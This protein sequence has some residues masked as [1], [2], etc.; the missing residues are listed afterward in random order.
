MY[1]GDYE[2]NY[3]FRKLKADEI[4]CRIG[5]VKEDGVSLLLYKD[6]RVDM[7]ILDETFGCL[8]W[9]REHK[10]VKGVN[11]CGVS[12]YN[13]K[14]GQWITK[15]DAGKESN[16]EAEKGEA[17]DSFKRACVNFGIG[18][19]LYTSPKI[20]IKGGTRNDYYSVRSI[21]IS[22]ERVITQLEIIN[23]RSREVV[24][25]FPKSY[26]KEEPKEQP[27]TN[28]LTPDT[29][30][31]TIDQLNELESLGYELYQVMAKLNKQEAE[32]TF[33]DMESVLKACRLQPRKKVK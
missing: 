32:I 9:Q 15:Y 19:E 5:Q 20:F 2:M 12:I 30:M 4:E 25:S 8:N 26:K 17:S 6:A 29:A 14:L 33:A 16:T 1:K 7:N 28:Q 3:L 23:N 31:F 24:F 11:Y 13:E 18:R 27:K 21:T 10:E 22:D